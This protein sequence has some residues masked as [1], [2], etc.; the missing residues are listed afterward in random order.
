MNVLAE[1]GA[2]LLGGTVRERRSLGGGSLSNLVQIALTDGR[3]AIVK[4]GPSPR[5][6]SGMLQAL[7][8]AGAPAPN[9][10]AANDDVL[11]IE[12]LP[13]SGGVGM[14]WSDL[15]QVLAQLHASHGEHYGWAE[16]Y[17]FGPVAI[18]NRWSQ[19]WP[20]FWAEHRLLNSIRYVGTGVARR[21]EN[22]CADLANRLPQS[23]APSLL[24]GDLWGGNVLVDGN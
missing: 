8:A 24:H 12:P 13:S 14:A 6:E 9:V 23:P 20:R 3:Q 2:A 11:V 1:K 15:G 19:D 22:L 18:V 10:F 5:V 7:R 16:D 4:S 21:L 17:A